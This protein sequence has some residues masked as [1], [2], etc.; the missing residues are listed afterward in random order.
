M[1]K[2]GITIHCIQPG[3]IISEQIVA[4]D[5]TEEA[6][7]EFAQQNIPV[8]RFGNPNELADLVCFLASP[9]AG[10]MR[11]TVIPVDGGMK[12]YAH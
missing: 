9:R 1:G 10:Y 3:R 7:R 8:G 5:P 4:H 11:G 2:Y 6:R 12:R